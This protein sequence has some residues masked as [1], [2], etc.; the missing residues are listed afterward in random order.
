MEQEHNKQDQVFSINHQV[1]GKNSTGNKMH[2]AGKAQERGREGSGGT[3]KRSWNVEKWLFY[4]FVFLA[5]VFFLPATLS[6]VG[7]NKMVLAGGLL[8]GALIAV[9]VRLLATGNVVLPPKHV[10][11]GGVALF[12]AALLSA[13]L[14]TEKSVSFIGTGP[15][16][17]FW[18]SLYIVALFLG[19]TVLRTKKAVLTASA[20]FVAS[21]ALLAVFGLMQFSGISL[22]PFDFAQNA[23][24]NPVGSVFALAFLVGAAFVGVVSYLTTTQTA[25]NK[26]KIERGVLWGVAVLFAVV[27]FQVNL[28]T[29]WLTLAVAFAAT[30]GILG[31]RAAQGG[32]LTMKPLVVP[33]FVVMVAILAIVIQPRVPTFISVPAELGP[34]A[35]S[36]WDISSEAASGARTVYGTG[37]GTFQYDYTQNRPAAL[38]QTDFW[39]VQFDQGY[40]ASLSWFASLGVLGVIAFAGLLGVVVYL[41]ARRMLRGNM[42]ADETNSAIPL[43]NIVL[44]A[45][46]VAVFGLV[47]FFFYKANATLYVTLFAVSG[48]G[49]AALRHGQQRRKELDLTSNPRVMLLASLAAVVLI[50]TSLGALYFLGQ[51]YT[52]RVYAGQAVAAF[53]QDQ[54]IEKA[55]NKLNSA[56][57]VNQDDDVVLR[58]TTQALLARMNEILNSQQ[59]ES[60]QQQVAQQFANVYQQAVRTARR[61]TQVNPS[62][63]QNWIQ[64]ARVY[65]Q[66]I[67]VA[68]DAETLAM[69]AYDQARQRDPNN[70]SLP[71]AQARVHLTFADALQAQLARGAQGGQ[72]SPQQ[73][74]QR[75]QQRQ[76]SLEA[77]TEKLNEAL[78]LKGNYVEA[79][80]LLASTYSRLG[81]LDGAVEET[82]KVIAS[83]GQRNPNLWFQLGLYQYEDGDYDAASQT[84]NNAV[85]LADGTFANARYYLGLAYDQ[86]GNRAGAIEQFEQLVRDNP[87]N[88]LV[89]RILTNLREERPALEGLEAPGKPAEAGPQVQPPI[90]DTG[91]AE[92]PPITP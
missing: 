73:E 8:L 34:S 69:D 3:K 67:G 12:G 27:L 38:N 13:V 80:L 16:S 6:P 66:V 32:R 81:N 46:G 77:A 83:G 70:P 91:G 58:T 87:D 10:L 20:L 15:D 40:A 72:A 2:G 11:W 4:A 25:T 39:A 60:Q 22:L 41:L 52:G 35:G 62:E 14:S 30:S 92:Q 26:N 24:F 54:D 17:L 89:F 71:L 48:V 65:E 44:G 88:D 90:P 59:D 28:W 23:N 43:Q 9:L 74:Q 29:L 51:K 56:L 5:P 19:A 53:R 21:V 31:W 33:L 42:N 68:Q 45:L 79:R 49:M 75:A 76:T 36:T 7:M 61:A 1:P 55:L 86:I 50:S 84:F 47:T 57:Q 63:V 18:I 64:L 78:A 85:A 82:Q 37:P